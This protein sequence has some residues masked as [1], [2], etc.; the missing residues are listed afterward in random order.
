MLII[1]SLIDRVRKRRLTY[2]LKKNALIYGVKKK[3][4]ITHVNRI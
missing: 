1:L 3:A 2:A 4:Y